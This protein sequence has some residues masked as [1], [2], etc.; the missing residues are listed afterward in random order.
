MS[1]S[2]SPVASSKNAC[3][4]STLPMPRVTTYAPIVASSAPAPMPAGE[5]AALIATEEYVAT[6]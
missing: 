5:P 6:A 4:S 2:A 1:A 3:I